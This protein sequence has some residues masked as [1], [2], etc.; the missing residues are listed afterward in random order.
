[1]KI[2]NNKIYNH[3]NQ[4]VLRSQINLKQQKKMNINKNIF[5]MNKN[6]EN[7]KITF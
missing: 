1:M 3:N 5:K 7:Y 4:T 2:Q 6:K